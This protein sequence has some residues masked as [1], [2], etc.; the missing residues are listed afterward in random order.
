MAHIG[1]LRS[2]ILACD[3]PKLGR[4][5]TMSVGA[6]MAGSTGACPPCGGRYRYVRILPCMGRKQ[7]LQTHALACPD[8]H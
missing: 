8:K 4:P 5:G 2:S 6:A 1:T 3:C 7:A